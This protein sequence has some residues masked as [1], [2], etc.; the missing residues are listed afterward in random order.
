MLLQGGTRAFWD[1]FC[2]R[3]FHSNKILV[4]LPELIKNC[5]KIRMTINSKSKVK[6]G[7]TRFIT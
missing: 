7:V 4:L 1:L 5:Y 3:E 6:N 2:N